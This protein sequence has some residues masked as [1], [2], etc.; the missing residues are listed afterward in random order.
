[1]SWIS[2]FSMWVRR[3]KDY[4]HPRSREGFEAGWKLGYAA[5]VK[6]KEYRTPWEGAV[7]RQSGA[8]SQEEIDHFNAR[9]QMGR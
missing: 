9:E 7:D 1:M 4:E 5:G 8:Y 6:T 2:D 3:S